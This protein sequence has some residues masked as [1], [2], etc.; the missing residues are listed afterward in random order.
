MSRRKGPYVL[1]ESEMAEGVHCSGCGELY[2]DM[3][4]IRCHQEL[5]GCQKQLQPEE[6]EEQVEDVQST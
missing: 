6:K 2:E 4:S 5:D 1:P 3:E